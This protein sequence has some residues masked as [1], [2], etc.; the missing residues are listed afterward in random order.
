MAFF[1]LAVAVHAANNNAILVLIS[2]GLN[3]ESTSNDESRLHCWSAHALAHG[4]V[5]QLNEILLPCSKHSPHS[6]KWSTQRLAH[7]SLTK[8]LTL[9][10]KMHRFF[11]CSLSL[12]TC[13]GLYS[14]PITNSHLLLK[15]IDRYTLAL[16]FAKLNEAAIIGLVPRV[17]EEGILRCTKLEILFC[18]M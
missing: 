9:P 11:S 14:L 8:V 6:K 17:E 5:K 13:C 3:E 1:K 12:P 4:S 10:S 2:T 15:M 7:V 18:R 16:D